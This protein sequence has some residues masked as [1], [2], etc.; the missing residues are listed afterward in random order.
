M[1]DWK[2]FFEVL[3]FTMAKML[4]SWFQLFLST[5]PPRPPFLPTLSDKGAPQPATPLTSFISP[6]GQTQEME[7]KEKWA[8]GAPD[9]TLLPGKYF[10][11]SMFIQALVSC[12]GVTSS[13]PARAYHTM[14]KN[15]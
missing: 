7:N 4:T 3:D 15:T 2:D 13:R 14:H 1:T 9:Q 8:D 12:D 6:R 10:L 5:P 11:P